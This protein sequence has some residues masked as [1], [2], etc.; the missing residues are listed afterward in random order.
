MAVKNFLLLS[1]LCLMVVILPPRL[2]AVEPEYIMNFP[3]GKRQNLPKRS[4]PN[5]S[6][7][8]GIS[9][10][11]ILLEEP[12]AQTMEP[13]I[14]LTLKKAISMVTDSNPSISAANFE[15]K[16]ARREKS[17]ASAA[18]MPVFSLQAMAK[19]TNVGDR[20]LTFGEMGEMIRDLNA[21]SAAIA[22]IGV[23]VPIYL[24][25]LLDSAERMAERGEKLAR[26][27]KKRVI[28]QT[29]FNVI[30]GYL[31]ILVEQ[32]A[33]KLESS[34]L[35]QKKH[36]IN[37]AR[38]KANER[39]ALKQQV[40]A[41]ELEANEIRRDKLTHQNN[42]KIARNKLLNELGIRPETPVEVSPRVGISDLIGSEKEAVKEAVKNNINLQMLLEKIGLATEQINLASAEEKTKIN[43]KWAYFHT[44]PFDNPD[45]QYDEW[46]A[47]LQGKINIFD[48]GRTRNKRLKEVDNLRKEEVQLKAATRQ[49]ELRVREAF[50]RYTEAAKLLSNLDDN[51]ILAREM[52]R[53]V[54]ER[55]SA[56]VLLKD[57]LL[58]SQ[59]DLLDA[60]QA[61][62]AVHATLLKARAAIYLLTGGLTID[63]VG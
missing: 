54:D 19:D 38:E 58:K 61:K 20:W 14:K 15:I 59:V 62:F 55:V 23:E 10:T 56:R 30:S 26:L 36:E 13:T 46:E 5:V 22:G 53:F 27:N 51:I 25:G 41:L 39:F 52:L 18:R 4:F 50:S 8:E 35:D 37:T 21:D 11:A 49:V 7:K 16:M 43:F 2:E 32:N 29:I 57:A 33:V 48:G 34:R 6:E 9:G 45:N 17:A 60:Q 3:P 1:F 63:K 40:L 31:D 47:K 44:Y 24:G 12:K 28:Q 42:L